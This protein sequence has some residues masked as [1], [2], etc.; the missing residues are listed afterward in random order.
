MKLSIITINYN[1][2]EGLRK[3]L[4]SVAAQTYCDFEHIIV[5]GG[6][7]DGSV[8]IIEAYASD[9]AR[10]A[11]GSVL[12][13]S[14][15]DFVAVDSQDSTL[16]NGAQPHEVT[17]PAASTQP[18]IKWISEKDKGIYNAMNKGIEIALGRRKVNSF[19]RSELV[20]DKNKGIAMAKGEY[21]QFL[22][23]GDWLVDENSLMTVFAEAK[24]VDI[25]Y[26][27]RI[28]I[29]E[30]GTT[31]YVNYFPDTM[32]ALFL[33][34]GMISHQASFI[35]RDLFE[36]Y[37][38]YR[39]DLKYASD[40]EF[41]LKTFLLHNC[42]YLHLH[43]YVVYFDC[44]GISSVAANNEEMWSERRRV[45]A[46][47]LPAFA[48]DYILLEKYMQLL[49]G[50]DRRANKLGKIILKPVRKMLKMFHRK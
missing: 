17:Q 23:S 48:E 34:Q 25:I 14:N 40:W 8:E 41:F 29:Y 50:Y 9:M 18:S 1:N 38:L 28:N 42:S 21:L 13:G 16:A 35:K 45:F 36:K 27:D 32:T 10:M 6:S 30:D 3:T 4:E 7:T 20:E 2:A 12:M 43:Q 39:E 24:N 5:D 37:G 31:R 15:G 11:S 49:K 22:N 46:E 26:G 19:N 47:T 44:A 33:Y